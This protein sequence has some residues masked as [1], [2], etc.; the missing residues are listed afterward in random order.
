MKGL[1]IQFTDTNNAWWRSRPLVPE[2]LG[3]T[4]RFP[5]QNT[6]FQPIFARSDS[7]VAASEKSSIITNRKSITSFPTSLR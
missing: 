6:D 3:Q 4:D 1:F 5:L 2:I 7:A